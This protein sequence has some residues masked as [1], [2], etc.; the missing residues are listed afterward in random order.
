MK[1]HKSSF[2]FHLGNL[3][4]KPDFT[5]PSINISILNLVKGTTKHSYMLCVGEGLVRFMIVHDCP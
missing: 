3:V 4:S 5:R 2:I 1:L